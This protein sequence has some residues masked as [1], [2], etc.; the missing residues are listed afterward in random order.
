MH[1][2]ISK[3]RK[4]LPNQPFDLSNLILY[5]TGLDNFLVVE[6]ESVSEITRALVGR[7]IFT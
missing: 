7:N 6:I 2:S 1:Y 3:D 4:H 5:N